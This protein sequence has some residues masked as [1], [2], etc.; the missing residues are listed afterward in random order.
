MRTILLKQQN[1]S[2]IITKELVF[3]EKNNSTYIMG[4]AINGALFIVLMKREFEQ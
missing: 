3:K 1:G 2:S 4:P